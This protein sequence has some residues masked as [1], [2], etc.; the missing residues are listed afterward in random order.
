MALPPGQPVPLPSPSDPPR[1]SARLRPAHCLAAALAA[2]ALLSASI[3]AASGQLQI[4]AHED[5]DLYFMTPA[6]PDGIDSGA[7]SWTVFLTAGDAGRTDGH[8]ES[9]ELG[10]RAAYASMAGVPDV[11]LSLPLFVEG[12][13]LTA[14]ALAGAAQIVVVF[15][16]LPDGNSTGTGYP[17]TGN[18][19][20]RYLWELAPGTLI[21]SI[22]GANQYT[23]TELIETL[24][25]FIR[26]RDPDV[27]RIQDMTDYHGSDHSDHYHSGRFAFDAH[28]ASGR[29]HRL[30]AYRAYNISSEPVN[31][32]SAEIAQSNAIITTYGAYDAGVGPNSWNQREIPIADVDGTQASLVWMGGGPGDLCLAAHDVATS[33]ESLDL[34]PC[35]DVPEQAFFFT[36][37]EIRHGDHCLTFPA[38]GGSGAPIG[39][40]P[41]GLATGQDW[42]FWSDGHVR[43]RDGVCLVESA[44]AP[45]LAPCSGASRVW[46]VGA[47]PAFD[48]S[49]GGEYSSVEF[50][51]DPARY[52]S[53]EFG[54]LDAD[55][56]EDVCARRADGVYCARAIGDG[57]FE[58]ATLW[59]PNFGDDDAWAPLWHSTTLALGDID[60]DNRADLCGRG[61]L[62]LYCVRSNG[63]A[64]FDFR[65]WTPTF[66]NADGGT[67]PETW[68]S[69]RLG[70]VTGD[71][72]DDVCGYRNGEIQCL[73]SDGTVFGS[74]TTWMT[75]NWI[76]LLGLGSEQIAQTMMLGDVDGDGDDDLCER[77]AAG[78]YCALADPVA[79]EFVDPAMRSQ[80]EFSD[81][82]GWS[83]ADSY[84]GSIR[85]GDF[86]GDGQADL[87][88]RGGAGV[89]CL[90][91]IDGRFSALNHRLSPEF[92]NVGGYLPTERGS[93]LSL[94]D[95]DGDGRKDLCAAGAAALRCAVLDDPLAAPEPGF[96]AGL[97]VGALV[98]FYGIGRRSRRR[99][100]PGIPRP[101]PAGRLRS[102]AC[103]DSACP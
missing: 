92:S 61:G 15:L 74:P 1:P 44:G 30:R 36:E 67:Q 21:H 40:A 88:G 80:G 42:T 100:R 19:S 50:G 41:C 62:G 90:Y 22:D 75:Q 58:S 85:L 8:W 66:S 99:L 54:D 31:L 17:V 76:T 57:A 103:S 43:G 73:A 96:G 69:I 35:A 16:R 51:T 14:Y 65:L 52:E 49:A 93:T 53:L 48:A 97:A 27:L 102:R 82:L 28:L 2:F 60:G 6:L 7:P 20:L 64:F 18:E 25:A 79:G 78:V 45:S 4:V 59:H 23:R 38:I 10:I 32:S 70:D 33:T 26:D 72:R 95:V 98:S 81:G 101:R 94:A 47:K 56:L 29:R 91:S 12:R 11:W 89:L 34:E 39:F 13:S 46:E 68:G 87:C 71:G 77:G 24:T 37:R 5:D 63:A 84:W 55:G 9:R 3:A 83:G 86:S